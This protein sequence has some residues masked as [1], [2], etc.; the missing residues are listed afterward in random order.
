MINNTEQ[1]ITGGCKSRSWL[2]MLHSHRQGRHHIVSCGR[3]RTC[4][5][6]IAQR[7]TNPCALHLQP[8]IHCTS[9]LFIQITVTGRSCQCPHLTELRS[10]LIQ[11]PRGCA[12]A[13]VWDCLAETLL[14]LKRRRKQAF[15]RAANQTVSL[16]RR[17]K[18][19]AGDPDVRTERSPCRHDPYRNWRVPVSQHPLHSVLRCSLSWINT[20]SVNVYDWLDF[21]VGVIAL[22][23]TEFSVCLRAMNTSI[24][25]S[26]YILITVWLLYTFVHVLK[27]PGCFLAE[28]W[29]PL[30]DIWVS[31]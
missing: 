31:L 20:A 22:W 11:P 23:S 17:L 29:R 1:A 19:R 27:Y 18:G 2:C 4:L 25:F 13:W 26:P 7:I 30:N 14:N 24:A 8:E 3:E 5:F 10:C 16:R 6:R 12:F 9:V 21:K 15:M 28:R